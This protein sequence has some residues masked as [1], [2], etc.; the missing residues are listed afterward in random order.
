[1]VEPVAVG[2]VIAGKYR[3]DSILGKGGMGMVVAATHLE[4]RKVRAIKLMLP[5]ANAIPMAT[6][7]FLREARAAC[8]LKSEHVAHVFDVGRLESGAPF[9]VME[10]LEGSDLEGELR[11]RVTFPV[12]EAVLYALQV[13]E[14]LAE[15]HARGIVHRDLKPGNL[16]L[17]AANDGSP[18]VKVLDFGISKL[19]NGHDTYEDGKRTTSGAVLGSPLYMSPEQIRAERGLDGRSDIWG[20]GVILY[21][22]VT[23]RL[24]FESGSTLQS[25]A[26]I[27]EEAPELPSRHASSSPPAFDAVIL[28]CLEKRPADRY[29]DVAGLARDLLPFAPAD[30]APLVDRIGRVVVAAG[31]ARASMV[32]AP[33]AVAAEIAAIGTAITE[34][35]ASPLAASSPGGHVAAPQKAVIADSPAACTLPVAIAPPPPNAA[36]SPSPPGVVTASGVVAE[37]PAGAR[38][39]PP[40]SRRRPARLMAWAIGLVPLIVGIAALMGRSSTTPAATG[41]RSS[42]PSSD[43]S[44]SPVPLPSLDVRNTVPVATVVISSVV[45]GSANPLASTTASAL[46]SPKLPQLPAHRATSTSGRPPRY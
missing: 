13:C 24:P 4:L 40:P 9:M 30:A 7:R 25:L 38:A 5:E 23:G 44:R 21:Q 46:R 26:L 16:F 42:D 33:D 20:L 34:R 18:R 14:A 29:Q 15:A 35:S 2:D 1:M 39:N 12:E 31:S 3:V 11:K 17:S 27:L 43:R 19:I 22:L 45:V 10:H 36:P 28:R 37:R 6:E 41:S 8:D 32:S